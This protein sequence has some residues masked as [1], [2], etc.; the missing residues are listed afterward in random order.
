MLAACFECGKKISTEARKCPRCGYDY[1]YYFQGRGP[2]G[3]PDNSGWSGHV[4]GTVKDGDR[5]RR[6][7]PL[8]CV[9]D[10]RKEIDQ[11]RKSKEDQE[12]ASA[13]TCFIATAAYGTPL[14][15]EVSALRRYRDEK[16]SSSFMGRGFISAYYRLSP[17]IARVIARYSVLRALTRAFLRP[18]IWILQR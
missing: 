8:E 11:S 1:H 4:T 7:S 3:R 12:N 17:P 16:L 6:K 15:M 10:I 2:D 18:V 14:A 5:I 13:S 9:T